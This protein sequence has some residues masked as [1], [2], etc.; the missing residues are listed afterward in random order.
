MRINCTAGRSKPAVKLSWF[1]NGEPA[2]SLHLRHYET[3]VSIR[4]GLETATLGL[5]FRVEQHH[6]QHGDMKLKVIIE[7]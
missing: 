6:F 3:M 2:E 5:E 4:D 7:F 1:I